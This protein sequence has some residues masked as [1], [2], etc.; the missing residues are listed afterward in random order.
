MQLV[1]LTT[2]NVISQDG[3]RIRSLVPIH[4]HQ[5]LNIIEIVK[6]NNFVRKKETC[7]M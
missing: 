5:P 7:H 3:P 1:Y 6:G 4:F 2:A